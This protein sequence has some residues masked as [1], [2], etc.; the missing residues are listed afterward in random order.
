M[1]QCPASRGCRTRRTQTVP[2]ASCACALHHWHI[3]AIHIWCPGNCIL[4]ATPSSPFVLSSSIL[5]F[6]SV[7]LSVSFETATTVLFTHTNKTFPPS[8][9]LQ[10]ETDAN[11]STPKTQIFY[12]RD[13]KAH[14]TPNHPKTE[15]LDEYL[16]NKQNVATNPK[17]ED[18]TKTTDQQQNQL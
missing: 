6:L 9:D 1:G 8:R 4:L 5:F 13:E 14:I 10:S 16:T 17:T 7:R 18:S 3:R 15:L 11:R 2:P 12:Q